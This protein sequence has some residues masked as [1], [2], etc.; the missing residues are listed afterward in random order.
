MAGLGLT[1]VCLTD[2]VDTCNEDR[3]PIDAD[4]KVRDFG[5]IWKIVLQDGVA[6]FAYR[7]NLQPQALQLENAAR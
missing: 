6:S 7:V 5:D 2:T 4:A 1:D 3:Y